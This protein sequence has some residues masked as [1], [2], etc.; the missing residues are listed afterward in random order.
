ME[1]ERQDDFSDKGGFLGAYCI[2]LALL[3][4][5]RG[6]LSQVHGQGYG[7]GQEGELFLQ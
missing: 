4:L 6:E 1:K 3:P 7:V 2:W 5:W